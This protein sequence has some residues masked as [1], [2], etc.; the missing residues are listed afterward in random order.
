MIFQYLQT[1]LQR[2]RDHRVRCRIAQAFEKIF[3]G[4]SNRKTRSF[5]IYGERTFTQVN[6]ALGLNEFTNIVVKIDN[7]VVLRKKKSLCGEITSEKI[8]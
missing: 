1:N 3:G 4:R 6:R 8:C 2:F 5:A 7:L